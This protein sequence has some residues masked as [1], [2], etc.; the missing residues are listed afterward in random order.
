MYHYTESG[1][2]NVWLVNGYK[3]HKTAYGPGR[4]IEDAHGLHR[5]IALWIIAN[6]KRLSGSELRFLRKEL[7]LSQAQLARMLGCE[8]QTVS[9][10]ERQGRMPKMAD[11]FVR[12][13]YREIAEGNAGIREMI[14]RLSVEH[15]PEPAR[16]QFA[17]R[18]AE[19]RPAA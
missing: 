16:I 10:W 11:R 15:G 14:E 13:I 19:W 12:A 3:R 8:E 5:T 4:S 1:L 2:R 7:D 6:R 18:K 9:L 17:K